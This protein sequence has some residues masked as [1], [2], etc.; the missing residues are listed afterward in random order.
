MKARHM[1]SFIGIDAFPRGWV[2]VYL[3][4]D[5]RQEF[6]YA[7]TVDRLLAIPYSRAMIDVPIGLP[8][9]GY[10]VCDLEAVSRVGSRSSLVRGGP[11]G[12]SNHI[13]MP[14][15]II[16]PTTTRDSRSSF[17]AFATIFNRSMS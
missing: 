4:E 13:G 1:G 10:R 15:P 11:C 16:G 12:R 6:D 17:G 9:R 2:A 5:G 14:M 7:P 8:T 3:H